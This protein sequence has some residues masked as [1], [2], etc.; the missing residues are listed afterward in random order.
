[1][2]CSPIETA[3]TSRF[4]IDCCVFEKNEL[5]IEMI[6]GRADVSGVPPGWDTM[7]FE[8]FM[9]DVVWRAEWSLVIEGDL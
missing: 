9:G 1:M 5:F 4:S 6:H 8:K 7:F 2:L 3:D